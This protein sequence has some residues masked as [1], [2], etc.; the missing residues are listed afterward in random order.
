MPVLCATCKGTAPPTVPGLKCCS[1]NFFFHI[2]CINMNKAQYDV[3]KSTDGLDWKCPNCRLLNANGNCDCSKLISDLTKMI[4]K[5]NNT[6]ESLQQ[7]ISSLKEKPTSADI[8][9]EEII[10]EVVD[11][12]HRQKN[13]IIY[14]TPE[15]PANISSQQRTSDDQ[16]FVTDFLSFLE[17]DAVMP[18]FTCSRLGKYNET[19][20]TSRPIKLRFDIEDN[21]VQIFRRM[22]S[23]R[24][25]LLASPQY[26]NLKVSSDRTPKQRSLFNKVK[27]ELQARTE[28]GEEGLTLKH[29]NGIPRIVSVNLN[30]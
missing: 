20:T 18:N 9:F 12:Q 28:S 14:N 30:N 8:E 5:L 6:V 23:R 24:S 1:C 3:I 15:Q 10:R 21:V 26:K 22:K 17:P 13:L 2:K 27:S 16:Q 29:V 4:E 11:R 25:H 7:Q 19:R